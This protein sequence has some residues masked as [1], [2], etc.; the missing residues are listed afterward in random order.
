MKK[1]FL[2]TAL[3]MV[4]VLMASC[5]VALADDD[6]PPPELISDNPFFSTYEWRR[7]VMPFAVDDPLTFTQVTAGIS[8][9][10]SSSVYVRGVSE[11]NKVVSTLGVILYV[12]QWKDNKWNSYSMTSF[13]E[14]DTY[15]MSGSKVVDVESGYYYR[16]VVKH[17]AIGLGEHAFDVTNTKSILVN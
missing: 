5:A 9:Y 3:L 13:T 12:E 4:M 11:T 6:V 2:F 15:S 16:L 10:S 1:R 14:Y 7:T 8:K 17:R